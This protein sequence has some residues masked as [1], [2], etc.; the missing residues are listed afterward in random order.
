MTE[1]AHLK[2]EAARYTGGN[3]GCTFRKYLTMH[4]QA[5]VLMEQNPV[6][7]TTYSKF[8]KKDLIL[9]GI[10]CPNLR[11]VVEVAA[12]SR[13]GPSPRPSTTSAHQ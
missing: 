5:H 2:M 10:K 3:K 12:P 11:T 9:K 13:N 8:H 6:L 7:S 4:L 1:E